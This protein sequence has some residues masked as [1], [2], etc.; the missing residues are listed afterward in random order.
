MTT[1]TS[2]NPDYAPLARLVVQQEPVP[3]AVHNLAGAVPASG[4]VSTSLIKT[5]GFSL[6]S[7]GITVSQNGVMS[8]QRYLD[9]GGTQVQGVA[10]S[11]PLIATVAANLDVLDGK[12]FASFVLTVTN[13]TSSTATI[14][15]FA[16]LLQSSA[17]NASDTGIDGSTSI[18][19]GGT[20]QN[21][22]GGVTPANGFFVANP[23]AVNDLWVSLGTTA[24]ANGQ[25]SI[26]LPASGYISSEPNMKPWQA[27]SVV[28]A[29][30][31]QKITAARW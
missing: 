23:D 6:I 8:I 15:G 25:G 5:D 11:V 29:V 7:A 21:L 30:T 14:N 22:F 28:G 18:A 2:R 4:N 26:R 20:A 27:I 12:P 19:T 1:E 16:L 31:G 10:L 9:D 3:Q 13:S 17:A 24:L